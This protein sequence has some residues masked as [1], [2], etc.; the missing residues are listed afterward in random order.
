MRIAQVVH[1]FY[2]SIGGIENHVYELGKSLSE[3]EDVIVYT[4]GKER[5]DEQLGKISVRR[6]P[7]FKFPFFSAVNLSPGL[8][9]ALLGEKADIFHSHGFGSTMPFF[10]SIIAKLKGKPFIFTLHGYPNQQGALSIFQ[11][12]YEIF[13]AP[14]FLHIASRIITVSTRIPPQLLQYKSKITYIPNGVSAS[15]SCDSSFLGQQYISYVGRLDEDKG[16]DVLISAF[17]ML[18]EPR[19]KLRIC[20]KDEGMREKL[21]ALAKEK[22][23]EVEFI[24]VPYEKVRE[25]Y[26]SSKAIVLPS[27]YEGFPLIWLEAIACGRPI[28]STR[29]GDYEHF[30]STVFG[31][32][33]DRFLFSSEAELVEKLRRMIENGVQYQLLAE[34]SK[35]ALMKKYAWDTVSK[36]T[37]SVYV[38][39]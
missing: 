7:A 16:I 25:I 17:A 36:Q 37:V 27:K 38:D 15:F 39:A 21:E 29:V 33:A 6:F 20:G 3:T 23:V 18:P 1:S 35:S 32:D 10:T 9:F 5:K 31:K 13:M 26:C 28:F 30:F 19:P 12:F 14:V 4:T 2:P 24:Q 22:K 34:R 8:L 11:K